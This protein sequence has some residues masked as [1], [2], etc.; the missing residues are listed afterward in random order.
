MQLRVSHPPYREL[1][2]IPEVPRLA[3]LAPRAAN[4]FYQAPSV[5]GPNPENNPTGFLKKD[6]APVAVGRASCTSRG[7][8]TICSHASRLVSTYGGGDRHKRSVCEKRSNAPLPPVAKWANPRIRTPVLPNHHP[9]GS[10]A[11]RFWGN[12]SNDRIPAFAEN[13]PKCPSPRQPLG[14]HCAIIFLYPAPSRSATCASPGLAF[15]LFY[16]LQRKRSEPRQ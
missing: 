14:P 5:R 7:P 2:S 8:N 6:H 13:F 10:T 1:S 9:G 15:S 11:S 12:Q 3:H 4:V 16:T